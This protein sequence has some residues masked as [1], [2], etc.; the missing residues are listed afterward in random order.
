[1]PGRELQSTRYSILEEANVQASLPTAVGDAP[2]SAWTIANVVYALHTLA[3][4]VGAVGTATVIG[5]F[6]WSIPSVL[7][8]IL[9]Y[10]K[11]SDAHGTWLESHYRWQIRTFWFAAFWVFGAWILIVTIIGIPIAWAI[12]A[13]TSAWLIYRIARGWLRLRDRRPMYT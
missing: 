8:V 12:L 2:E 9:N 6:L 13:A 1:M 3:I 10:A 7:A 5:S 4:I 11:R